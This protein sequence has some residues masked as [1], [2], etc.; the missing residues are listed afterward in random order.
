MLDKKKLS[1]LVDDLYGAILHL[2]TRRAL[3]HSMGK[4]LL[5]FSHNISDSEEAKKFEKLSQSLTRLDDTVLRIME[6]ATV[7]DIL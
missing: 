6:N 5:D 2:R 3:E 1:S 4:D 7:L